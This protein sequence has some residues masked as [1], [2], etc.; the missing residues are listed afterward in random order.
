VR[1][2]DTASDVVSLPFRHTEARMPRRAVLEAFKRQIEPEL[3]ARGF[4]GRRGHFLRRDPHGVTQV[5]ELQHSIYG[6]RL[7]ANLG[8]DLEF[9]KPLVRWIPSPALGPHAHD[10][11]RW[12]RIGLVRPDHADCWWAFD[13]DSDD[14]ADEAARS[15]GRAILDHG[16]PWLEAESD[17]KS[18]VHY[19][20]T[21]LERSKC[22]EHPE[23]CFL[24]L[25]LM[26]AVLAWHGEIGHAQLFAERAR[27]SW[28]DERARLQ[29]ARMAFRKKHPQVGRKVPEVPDIQAELDR[30]ISTTR[31]SRSF[32]ALNDPL[33]RPSMPRAKRSKS[34]PR[35]PSPA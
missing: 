8:L 2:I 17:S 15:A 27:L 11:T 25:R 24:E 9:I 33:G 1:G 20:E 5:I 35:R 19:A 28:P 21:R 26:A 7:T 14:G 18:F 29:A 22:A 6:G 13:A 16:L 32:E 10:A 3:K 34:A 23:G 12:I 31:V 4:C 30:L